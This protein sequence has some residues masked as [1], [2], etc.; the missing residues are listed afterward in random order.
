MGYGIALA[1][2]TSNS[3][4]QHTS[5]ALH[6]SES[7]RQSAKGCVVRIMKE[8]IQPRRPMDKHRLC[9]QAYTAAKRNYFSA[10]GQD[11]LSDNSAITGAAKPSDRQSMLEL[12]EQQ[13]QQMKDNAR[14]M[15]W[16]GRLAP[17]QKRNQEA[18]RNNSGSFS[19]ESRIRAAMHGA[20]MR[21]AFRTS[22][23]LS[24]QLVSSQQ[25]TRLRMVLVKSIL[26]V[27]YNML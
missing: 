21:C 24:A 23:V 2:H 26:G 12:P 27:V 11:L 10:V 5:C 4:L 17:T 16:P 20:T 19:N 8:K 13:W 22:V 18:L 14:R 9:V 15:A 1:R 6:L 25:K 7:C 3:L